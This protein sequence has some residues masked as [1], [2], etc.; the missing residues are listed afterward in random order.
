[1][2]PIVYAAGTFPDAVAVGDFNGD[3]R[4]D[5]VVANGDA[6]PFFG[7]TTIRVL[8]GNGDGSFHAAVPDTAGVDPRSVAV[9]DFNG[10]GVPDLAV[11]SFGTYLDFS[12]SG[13]SVLTGNG[14]GSFQAPV[15]YHTEASP[16]AVAVGDFNGDGAPD[17]ALAE[18]GNYPFST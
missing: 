14:D 6:Y 2:A 11:G 12:D 13:V 17:L 5:L 4:P 7:N 15:L 8:L 1:Q 10:D 16:M 18:G 3:G 9:G